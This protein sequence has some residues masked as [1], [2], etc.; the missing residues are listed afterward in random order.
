M[1]M[2]DLTPSFGG[3]A[4]EHRVPADTG[5]DPQSP[6][7]RRADSVSPENGSVIRVL[8]IH[9]GPCD[10]HLLPSATRA[11]SE[12]Y[13]LTHV[14]T[15]A[16][17]L[18]RL[19]ENRF[20]AALLDLADE[21][22]C[23]VA[24]VANLRS[25]HPHLPMIVLVDQS[26]ERLAVQAIQHGATDYLIKIPGQAPLL[27]R[28]IRLA[29]EI[30]SLDETRARAIEALR[31]STAK[32]IAAES[33]VKRSREVGRFILDVA[34]DAFVS[35]D[36][37]GRIRH[38]SR[39]AESL[40]GWS[41]PDALG[42][43]LAEIILPE[44]LRGAYERGLRHYLR[45]GKSPAPSHRIRG[46]AV[47]RDGREFPI[48]VTVWAV[49]SA[50]EIRFN[51]II[52]DISETV[53]EETV[54]RENELRYR[55]VFERSSVGMAIGR[56]DGRLLAANP[57]LER[58]LKYSQDEMLERSYADLV[59]PEDS[60]AWRR[61]L[62]ELTRG[63]RD[64]F[65][66]ARRFT[67]KDGET[68]VLRMTLSVVCDAEGR[69]EFI[70]GVAEEMTSSRQLET[71]FRRRTVDLLELVGS[72]VGEAAT[73]EEA[74]QL[75]L[76]QV[77]TRT[78][79]P[80]GH[81]LRVPENGPSQLVSTGL[82]HLADHARFGSLREASA[83]L[84]IPAGVGLPGKVLSTGKPIWADD[85]KNHPHAVRRDVAMM[86]GLHTGFYVPIPVG[87]RVAGVL[88][89]FST[90]RV[91]Y[92]PTLMAALV[93][94]GLQLG[95]VADRH[96]LGAFY[97]HQAHHDPLTGLPNRILFMDR[98]EHA[99]TRLERGST[100]VG[101]LFFDLDGFKEINDRSGHEA[102]DRLL[103]MLAERLRGVLRPGDTLA[104]FGGDEFTILCEDIQGERHAI[105]IAERVLDAV[106]EPFRIDE[107]DFRVTASIGIV[108][109]RGHHDLPEVLLRNADVAMY[110][111]KQRGGGRHELF[112]ES[113]RTRVLQRRGAEWSLRHA[114][115]RGELRLVYQ[116]AVSLRDGSIA[117]FEAL[118]RWD[119]PE[120]GML[121]PEE[122]IPLAEDSGLIVPI[123]AWVLEQACLQAAR[124]GG[125]SPNGKGPLMWINLS[126]RQL[127]RSD[128]P[129]MIANV[130]EWT[131]IQP[132]SVCLEITETALMEDV[133]AAV[134]ELEKLR[135]LGLELS[136]DDFGIGYSS[137]SCLQRLP[138]AWVKLDRSFIRALGQEKQNTALVAGV[139]NMAHA[140]DLTVVAE[141]VENAEQ[142]AEL[143]RLG[144]DC[145]QGFFFAHPQ[146]AEELNALIES[147][148]RW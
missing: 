136:I 94:I 87:G 147:G 102:G 18:E 32:P 59:A 16:E 129:R 38:W 116:P 49:P 3:A 41:R 101:V 137:L 25:H 139:I 112:D 70:S 65:Q 46:V 109:A 141:G 91:A 19:T 64:V 108:I 13:E 75:C 24:A 53:H 72:A 7:A 76:D 45:T 125:R 55:A 42:R 36:D 114:V 15:M 124:W 28:L 58:M 83:H 50:G 68:V 9:P 34:T 39:G 126:S 128:L 98:L 146:P 62:D 31:A 12:R 66:D 33:E 85:V 4:Q 88:E 145:A 44:R 52:R 43:P 121:E 134:Q 132:R 96:R 73:I 123:G 117:G 5:T 84:R 119:H 142:L 17:A 113:L 111:A 93:Q 1:E 37:V 67:R 140:L 6:A 133:D 107:I 118:L 95:K 122:F 69:P 127:G 120:R 27:P 89:F 115:E 30:E 11:G 35:I 60:D 2:S 131:G 138:I 100:R 10:R 143:R 90:G 99:L 8:L 97:A 144:C 110:R 22:T 54:L 82:W 40:F 74:I 47:H 130:F 106:A 51:A 61:Q 21:D 78:G 105:G 14:D 63:V 56:L 77:C 71:E 92:D 103:V 80:V 20:D 29:M 26:R 135:A 48:E 148:A 23:D 79:W 57:A 86:V 81:A 104:R